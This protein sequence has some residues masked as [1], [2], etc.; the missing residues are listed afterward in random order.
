MFSHAVPLRGVQFGFTLYSCGPF[1]VYYGFQCS[2][3]QLGGATFVAGGPA[4]ARIFW[5]LSLAEQIASCFTRLAMHQQGRHN[6]HQSLVVLRG[7]GLAEQEVQ[8]VTLQLPR[9]VWTELPLLMHAL[10]AALP[11]Y[12][13]LLHD[14]PD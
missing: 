13:G 1:A 3:S 12:R 7:V 14:N 6:K 4:A 10:C 2:T 8:Q 9:R 5:Q 11:H